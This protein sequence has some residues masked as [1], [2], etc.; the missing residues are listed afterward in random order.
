MQNGY[1]AY[2][3]QVK[4]DRVS[5]EETKEGQLRIVSDLQGRLQVKHNGE[6]FKDHAALSKF[7]LLPVFEYLR[8]NQ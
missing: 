7:L 4:S 6:P 5:S 2:S 3:R 8:K 1:I